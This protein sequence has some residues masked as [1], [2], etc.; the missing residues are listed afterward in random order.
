MAC[1]TNCCFPLH[2]IWINVSAQ[3]LPLLEF[4]ARFILPWGK[5]LNSQADTNTHACTPNTPLWLG[6]PAS[7]SSSGKLQFQD[8]FESLVLLCQAMIEEI[9]RLLHREP[10]LWVKELNKGRPYGHKRPA[11]YI[12]ELSD[13]LIME[14]YNTI[15]EAITRN[16]RLTLTADW[17]NVKGQ[18]RYMDILSRKLR[19]LDCHGLGKQFLFFSA[20]VR[21]CPLLDGN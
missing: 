1:T 21:K 12:P 9:N 4:K 18:Y 8:T 5:A 3:N 13:H 14:Y 6:R 20:I 15:M 16:T 10:H 17:L 11:F 2:D 19:N 7:Y